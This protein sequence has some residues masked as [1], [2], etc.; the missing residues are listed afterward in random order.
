MQRRTKILIGVSVFLLAVF[1]VRFWLFSFAFGLSSAT[2][3]YEDYNT[4]ITVELD[5]ADWFKISRILN[6]NRLEENHSRCP[7]GE[8]FSIT[9]NGQTFYLAGDSCGL[10][11]VA[12]RN[13]CFHI[14]DMKKVRDILEKYGVPSW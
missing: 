13:L 9:A 14:D 4:N 1:A 12:E 8:E 5:S 11:H 6:L 7:V 3:H 2:L 10:V